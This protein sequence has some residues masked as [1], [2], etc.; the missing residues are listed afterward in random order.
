MIDLFL[1]KQT[2]IIGMTVSFSIARGIAWPEERSDPKKKSHKK[3]VLLLV[4]LV[5]GYYGT[6]LTSINGRT[7]PYP[8]STLE[9]GADISSRRGCL[10]VEENVACY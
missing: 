3:I 8:M 5:V 6:T 2:G 7:K 1:S 4:F 9:E 10:V